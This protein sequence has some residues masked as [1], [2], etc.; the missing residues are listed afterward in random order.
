[1]AKVPN[2]VDITEVAGGPGIQFSHP[3]H[4]DTEMLLSVV[5]ALCRVE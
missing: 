1:M 2:G 4:P 5:S 3:D